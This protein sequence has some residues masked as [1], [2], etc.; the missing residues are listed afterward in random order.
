MFVQNA[1]RKFEAEA[2]CVADAKRL[3]TS[4][5]GACSCQGGGSNKSKQCVIQEDRVAT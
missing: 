5:F 2:F 4:G 3:E 1:S